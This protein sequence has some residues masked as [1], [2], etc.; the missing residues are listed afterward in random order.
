M[1]ASEHRTLHCPFPRFLGAQRNSWQA[2]LWSPLSPRVCIADLQR[3][4]QMALDGDPGA[5]GRGAG[6]KPTGFLDL[7]LV[8]PRP[9][10]LFAGGAVMSQPGALGNLTIG[11][12][13]SYA[14]SGAAAG[15]GGP[16]GRRRRQLGPQLTGCMLP[17]LFAVVQ[18]LV[19]LDI[20]EVGHNMVGRTGS[21]SGGQAEVSFVR[22]R[23]DSPHNTRQIAEGTPVAIKQ[24]Q[25]PAGGGHFKVINTRQ[26]L[27]AASKP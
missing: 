3:L 5:G 11:P 19:E 22:W 21:A 26:E 27:E 8:S 12:L 13:V 24:L 10:L 16:G 2:R 25:Q 6:W 20:R 15:G 18:G 14:A 23:T 7:L 4:L 17:E 1:H 9:K